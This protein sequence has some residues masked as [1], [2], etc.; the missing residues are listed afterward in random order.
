MTSDEYRSAIRALGLTPARPSYDGAT[1]H[2]DRDGSHIS[3]PDPDGLSFE[4]RMVMF[5]V[6]RSKVLTD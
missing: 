6:V 4:E 3:V 5:E 1:L 2:Q